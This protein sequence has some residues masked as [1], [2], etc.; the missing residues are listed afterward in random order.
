MG[1]TWSSASPT[2]TDDSLLAIAL[3]AISSLRT[4]LLGIAAATRWVLHWHESRR[5]LRAA[6]VQSAGEP[7]DLIPTGISPEATGELVRL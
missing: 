5:R 3:Q 7:G 4:A 1:V 6:L 2:S